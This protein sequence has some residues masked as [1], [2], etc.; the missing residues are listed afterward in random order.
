MGPGAGWPSQAPQP[1]T[2]NASDVYRRGQLLHSQ[3]TLAF[4][5]KQRAA[6]V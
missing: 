2:P 6:V 5:T 1:N 4:Q 3:V